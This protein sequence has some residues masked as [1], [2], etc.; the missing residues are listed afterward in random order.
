MAW[1]WEGRCAQSCSPSPRTADCGR[2][3]SAGWSLSLCSGAHPEVHILHITLQQA[4]WQL[5]VGV[6]CGQGIVSSQRSLSQV[7][8]LLGCVGCEKVCK[9][10]G[11]AAAL[12]YASVVPGTCRRHHLDACLACTPSKVVE[13]FHALPQ[14]QCRPVRHS[15]VNQA[16]VMESFRELLALLPFVGM[17]AAAFV[18]CEPILTGMRLVSGLQ[19]R[20]AA[21]LSVARRL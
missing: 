6:Q 9:A 17:H 1:Q 19:G 15:F 7:Q 3:R 18:A 10:A 14:S 8:L 11:P 4:V 2:G 13:A 5:D 16:G 21:A 12:T 20:L